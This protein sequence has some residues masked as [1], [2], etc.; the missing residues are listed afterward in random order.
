MSPGEDLRCRKV[1]QVAMI[2][3]DI[4]GGASPF[5]VV[6]PPFEGIVDSRKFLVVDVVICLSNFKRPGVEC[7]QMI[8][9]VWGVN[10]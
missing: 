3:Y 8:V 4:D 1:L 2:S 5:E 9:A 10:G 7:N 6:S